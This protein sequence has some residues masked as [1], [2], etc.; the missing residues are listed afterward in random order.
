MPSKAELQK[1]CEIQASA[2]TKSLKENDIL[3]S[4]ISQRINNLASVDLALREKEINN[5]REQ[6]KSID[7]NLSIWAEK[8]P[9]Y[10]K[11]NSDCTIYSTLSQYTGNLFSVSKS[12]QVQLNKL[13]TNP[14]P[15]DTYINLVFVGDNKN[16]NGEELFLD[17]ID[18]ASFGRGSIEV[19]AFVRSYDSKLMYG[20]QSLNY[21]VLGKVLTPS[22]CKISSPKY[23]LGS[24]NPFTKFSVAPIAEGKCSIGFSSTINNRS[25]LKSTSNTWTST[26]RVTVSSSSSYAPIEINDN[27]IEVEPT[28]DLSFNKKNDGSYA[29]KVDTNLESENIEIFATK[30]GSKTIKFTKNTG[31]STQF[32]LN[33]TRNLKGY[34][35]TV[36]FEGNVI[37]RIVVS[38]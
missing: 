4:Q 36:K 32:V 37:S 31:Q 11:N 10:L 38:K 14:T 6:I 21:E 35:L 26:V 17:G 30:K 25:D 7:Q 23:F 1:Q 27:G 28:A 29:I 9:Y 12:I 8:L 22:I 2:A 5:L 13:N 16:L 24:D 34:T 19:N 18:S 3:L 20:S 33:T 15:K